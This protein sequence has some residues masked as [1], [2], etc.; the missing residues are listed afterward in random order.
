VPTYE[1]RSF[2]VEITGEDG[3]HRIRVL[4]APYYRTFLNTHF[5]LGE[6]ATLFITGQQPKRTDAQ[7]R[8]YWVYVS[9]ISKETGNEPEDLHE[10]FKAKFLPRKRVEVLGETI[11][12]GSSTKNLTRT[13][14]SEYID[15]IAEMTGILPPPLENVRGI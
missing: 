1:S 11:E 3:D 14:F 12:R 8:Y 10:L 4:S 6:K 13:E 15:R 2:A 7:H 9:E 5:K